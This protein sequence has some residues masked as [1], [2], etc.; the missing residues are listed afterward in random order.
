MILIL[1]LFTISACRAKETT[2][3]SEG[4]GSEL[5]ELITEGPEKDDLFMVEKESSENTVYAYVEKDSEVIV[6]ADG[7][8]LTMNQMNMKISLSR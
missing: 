5:P 3:V 8:N 2:T 6:H 7:N 1:T 4:S